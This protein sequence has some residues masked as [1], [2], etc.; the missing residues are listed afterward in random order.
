MY[1]IVLLG[2]RDINLI[3]GKERQFYI[4]NPLTLS[5]DRFKMNVVG[6]ETIKVDDI[7]YDTFEIKSSTDFGDTVVWQTNDGEVIKVKA[8]MGITMMKE[9]MLKAIE[10]PDKYSQKD[11]AELTN[12]KVNKAIRNPR[13]TKYLKV[14]LT[15]INDANMMISDARQKSLLLNKT[16]DTVAFTINMKSFN[17]SKSINLPVTDIKLKPYMESTQYLDCTSK[18]IIDQAR[19]IAGNE[20]N[21]YKISCLIRKWVV[22]KTWRLEQT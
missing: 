11:F 8:L 17:Q 13:E 4:F 14:N 15:G 9:S 6:K 16:P 5:L 3:V 22:L 2:V 19:L 7:E 12:V 21:S 10:K 18:T 1:Q 20:K